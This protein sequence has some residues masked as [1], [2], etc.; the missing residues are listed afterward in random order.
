MR[1]QAR[2]LALHDEPSIAD[3]LSALTHTPTFKH[4]QPLLRIHGYGGAAAWVR[5]HRPKCDSST[6]TYLGFFLPL[7]ILGEGDADRQRVRFSRLQ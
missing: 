2:D 5:S 6:A 3:C 7:R 1:Q 4:R